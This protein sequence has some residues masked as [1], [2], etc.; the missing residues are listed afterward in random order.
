MGMCAFVSMV[1][2]FWYYVIVAVVRIQYV[3]P[4]VIA[5]IIMALFYLMTRKSDGEYSF[6]FS[7]TSAMGILIIF[8]ISLKMGL[9]VGIV[10][11]NT[12]IMPWFVAGGIHTLH[13]KN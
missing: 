7:L 10:I 8:V 13:T 1:L 5:S 11:A 2:T 12:C 9:P 6:R 4:G 3:I